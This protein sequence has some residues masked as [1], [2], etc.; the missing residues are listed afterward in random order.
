M[1][2][3][4][5]ESTLEYALETACGD[6][7]HEYVQLFRSWCLEGICL[8]EH[9]P[10]WA[11][12]F[13]PAF[14]SW[15]TSL[16]S[17]HGQFL[18]IQALASAWDQNGPLNDDTHGSLLKT[19]ADEILQGLKLDHDGH[20][21]E[22]EQCLHM[23]AIQCYL[24]A[25]DVA[26]AR[27]HF[28]Q[29]RQFRR[30]QWYFNWFCAFLEALGDKAPDSPASEQARQQF[31]AFFDVIRDPR[32]LF[33]FVDESGTPRQA[34]DNDPNGRNLFENF[35]LFSLRL[36]LLRWTYIEAKPIAGHWQEI[37]AQICR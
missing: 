8:A 11:E 19:A 28:S 21:D 36:A 33:P 30:T 23:Q 15:S 7:D 17:T 34:F 14:Q 5:V 32:S 3:S 12:D 2:A 29:R 9:D 26:A 22:T 20:W 13:E 25:G 10:R 1:P 4:T 35:P 27:K 6:Y 24:L 16:M 18:Y 37:I 31:D